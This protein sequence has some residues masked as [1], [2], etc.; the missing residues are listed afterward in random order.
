MD[1]LLS[2]TTLEVTYAYDWLIRHPA[3]WHCPNSFM[4]TIQSLASHPSESF[5]QRN[6][7]EIKPPSFTSVAYPHFVHL[8]PSVSPR[9][10]IPKPD[11]S[12]FRGDQTTR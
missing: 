4:A 7:H 6:P 11:T 3:A 10:R 2:N 1:Q 12:A 9:L 5:Q 8:N